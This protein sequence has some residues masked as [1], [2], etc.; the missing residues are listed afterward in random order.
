LNA[1]L[2]S[3]V[4]SALVG[5]SWVILGGCH[6]DTPG[7]EVSAE[8]LLRYVDAQLAFGARVPGSPAH[9]AMGQWLDS[10]LR[11]R[12]DQVVVDDWRHVTAAGDT[13]RLR[14][15]LARFL[16]DARER[17]LYIAHWDTRPHADAKASRDTIAPVPGANDGASGVAVLLGV[18]DALHAKPPTRGVDLLFVDGEDYGSFADTTETLI[19]A[20]R[21]VAGGALVPRPQFAIVWDMVGDRDQRFLQEGE[22]LVAAPDVVSH[23]WEL[24]GR[25]GY[26]S[27]FVTEPRQGITDDQI[28]F[29][30]A[31]V[32]A[33]DVID[34]DYGPSNS[35]HHTTEDTRDKISG[36]SLAVAAHVATALVRLGVE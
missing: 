34:L 7:R 30:H 23:V 31:G 10:L 3:V 6:A 24:A 15:V 35:W 25:L 2:R 14:N 20:R 9:R 32:K 17:V 11:S 27:R 33:I 28:P 16:P 26:A 21:F 1:Q 12:A 22:S 29:Q 13:L 8:A 19:G 4:G 36:E 5:L 18:A